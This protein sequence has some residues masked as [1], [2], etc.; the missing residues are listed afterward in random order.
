MQKRDWAHVV[1]VNKPMK[2]FDTLVPN[3]ARKVG[4]PSDVFSISCFLKLGDA[5]LV[6]V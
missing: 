4:H 3:L 6:S 2:N 5:P 1:E